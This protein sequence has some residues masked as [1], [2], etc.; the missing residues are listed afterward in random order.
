MESSSPPVFVNSSKE[1]IARVKA[2]NYAYMMESSM[3]EYHMERDCQ[4]QRIGGLLDS[5]VGLLLF[6]FVESTKFL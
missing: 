6:D 1:G 2:G 4:L 3:L 5:K